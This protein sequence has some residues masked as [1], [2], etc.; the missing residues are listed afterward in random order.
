MR[1]LSR[2][3]VQKAITMR[4]AIEIVRDAFAQLSNKEA[5]VP[6]RVPVNLPKHAGVTLFMPAYLAR[7]DALA[8]KIVSVHNDNPQRGLPLIHAVVAVIDA[9][10]GEPLALME[11]GYLT[12]LRTGAVSGVATD[13]LARRDAKTAA[14]FGAGVQGRAQLLAVAAVRELQRV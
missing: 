11:G 6:L 14:I 2:A 3:D 12:A 7:T 8:V 5:T 10:T 1:I 13:V 9:A 4:E